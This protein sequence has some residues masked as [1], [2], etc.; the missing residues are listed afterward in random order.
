MEDVSPPITYTLVEVL[1]EETVSTELSEQELH[2]EE[3]VTTTNSTELSDMDTHVE[4]VIEPSS[5]PELKN[6]TMT[7][8]LEG[9]IAFD[10]TDPKSE[11]DTN[12]FAESSEGNEDI[13][14]GAVAD[15]AIG[16]TED[17]ANDAVG[18][19][20]VLGVDSVN[21]SESALDA[22]TPAAALEM[23]CE[24]L[25]ELNGDDSSDIDSIVVLPSESSKEHSSLDVIPDPSEDAELI[26][27]VGI[28]DNSKNT[29]PKIIF[30]V[31]YRDRAEHM[32]RFKEQM[33]KNMTSVS[34]SHEIFFIHQTDNRPFN[35]GAMKNIGFLMVKSK[36]PLTYKH[37]TLVFNDVDTFPLD[38]GTITPTN[39]ETI[40]G[41]VKHFYGYTFALGGIVAINAFDFERI[42]GFPNYWSWGFEDNLL[43]SRAIQS[44]L[45]IDRSVFYYAGDARISQLN[46]S[47]YRTVNVAEFRRYAE[48]KPDGFLTLS[49]V[50]YS[51]EQETNFVHVTSFN[52]EH[53]PRPELD[54]LFDTRSG[55]QPFRGGYSS[56]RRSSM[57]LVF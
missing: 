33:I 15:D 5:L 7:N 38:P 44:K 48:R 32:K 6:N 1:A 10:G 35:R 14:S 22:F 13:V 24:D 49:D 50:Q 56:R 31:P 28:G 53:E 57:G 39:Y 4:P 8:P 29:D 40:E 42:H 26:A 30:I 45:F 3:S 37:M 23:I 34:S 55:N 27:Y 2:T 20:N 9:V 25:R 41:R 46:N 12:I 51:I 52:T 16:G 43:L 11:S 21:K 17:V 54:T 47:F 19:E 18:S 36:Y